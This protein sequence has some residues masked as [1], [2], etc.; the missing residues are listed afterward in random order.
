MQIFNR[1][2]FFNFLKFFL[3]AI[4]LLTGVALISKV[5]E[6]LKVVSEHLSERGGTKMSVFL[7]YFYS[8]P[9]LLNII[10]APALMFAVSYVVAMFTKSNEITVVMSAGQS[11]RKIM[12][13]LIIFSLVLSFGMLA[14]NEFV[15]YPSLTKSLDLWHTI[16]RK[17]T[18]PRLNLDNVNRQSFETR[19]ENRFYYM[20]RYNLATKEFWGLHLLQLNDDG[21][22]RFILEAEHGFIRDDEW[23]FEDGYIIN[24]EKN[25]MVS[26]QDFFEKKVMQLP[27][28]PY[29]F[30]KHIKSTEESTIF[31]HWETIKLQEVRGENTRF[32]SVELYWHIGFPFVCF[33]TVLIGGIIGSQMKKGAL[34]ASIG[35]STLFTIFYYVVMLVSK[36][37]G[38]GGLIPP[39]IAGMFANIL[40]MVISGYM[41]YKYRK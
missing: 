34:A 31:D 6:T 33:F 20:G 13:P 32:H 37:L 14:F 16:I 10:T 3:G 36:S 41:L 22:N 25:G 5:M 18:K 39:F 4:V 28:K 17:A 11:F 8:V 1:Y 7:F 27:D 26:E 9:Y 40:F 38:R 15:G 2:F 35:L 30:K 12:T 23:H 21:S 29:Y 19:A 24:F